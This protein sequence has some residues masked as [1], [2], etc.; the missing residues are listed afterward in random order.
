M[1]EA[2]AM[3][4]RRERDQKQFAFTVRGHETLEL[5]GCVPSQIFEAEPTSVLNKTYNGEWAYAKDDKRRA[6]INSEPAHWPLIIRW[7]SYGAVP[8]LTACTSD[9]IAECE[10]WQLENLLAK[11]KQL[12]TAEAIQHSLTV[13]AAKP[14]EHEIK[15]THH[16]EYGRGGFEVTG[17]IH[18]F[19]QR[20]ASSKN[21]QVQFQV[22]G[23]YWALRIKERG[24]FLALDAAP[25]EKQIASY[26]IIFGPRHHSWQ[27]PSYDN[28]EFVVNGSAWGAFWPGDDK[29]EKV[30]HY[31]CMDIQ[32]SLQFSAKVLFAQRT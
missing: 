11:I 32:G 23:A 4:A 19:V 2:K 27:L 25:S 12:R 22:Y 5:S 20:F 14:S 28:T 9:F 8:S 31:P 18:N 24:V 10:Y 3:S 30:Q 13:Q 21:V 15:I 7:L 16:E 26:S 17:R 6:C 1:A 29:G